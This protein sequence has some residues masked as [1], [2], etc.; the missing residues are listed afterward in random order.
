MNTPIIEIHNLIKKYKKEE[1]LNIDTFSFMFGKKYLISGEN[2]SGK[3]TLIKCIVGVINYQGKIQINTKRIGYLPER[4]PEIS[5]IRAKTFLDNLTIEENKTIVSEIID[6]FSDYFVLDV[7]KNISSLSKGNLQKVM[8]IQAL[9]NNANLL[10]FDEPLNGLDINNQNKFI[11]LLKMIDDGKK[12]I[13][14]TTHYPKYYQ[15]LYD[16]QI[17]IARGRINEIKENL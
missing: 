5:L 17:F 7:N 10:I 9:I 12:T 13:I 15:D 16:Y 2:G 6:Q 11:N 1:V 3:S 14:I 8:I 4:F